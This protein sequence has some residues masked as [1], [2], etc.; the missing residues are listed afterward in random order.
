MKLVLAFVR[1]LGTVQ[2]LYIMFRRGRGLE[3]A[4]VH[5]MGREFFNG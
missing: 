4:C 2:V 5:N 3:F 1:T